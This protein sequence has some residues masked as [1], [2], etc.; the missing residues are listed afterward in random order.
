MKEFSEGKQAFKDNMRL[1]NNPY[2]EK[3]DYNKYT[4]W[5]AGW[6]KAD[7]LENR[8]YVGLGSSNTLQ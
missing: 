8:E 6:L 5:A 1:E 3:S 7:A 2:N 4:D